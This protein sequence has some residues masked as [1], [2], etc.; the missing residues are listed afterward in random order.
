MNVNKIN[1]NQSELTYNIL[2]D[3]GYLY[4]GIATPSTN[5][6]TPDSKVVYFANTTGTYVH[7]NNI[8]V[9]ENQVVALYNIDDSWESHEIA[10]INITT[11][12]IVDGAVTTEKLADSA[13][14][15]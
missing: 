12:K 8:T 9:E 4:A 2:S 11:D 15:K 1:I 13:I 6:G 10:N 7:F 5:P 14:L 3:A